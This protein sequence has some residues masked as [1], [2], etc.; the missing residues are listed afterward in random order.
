ME[1]DPDAVATLTFPCYAAG[2]IG[3]RPALEATD[4]VVLPPK[5]LEQVLELR[6]PLPLTLEATPATA[7]AADETPLPP[8]RV[9]HCG[10]V[11]FTAP[12]GIAFVP[13]AIMRKLG[14]GEGDR[15][16]FRTARLPPGTYAQ[17][18]P[19]GEDW[20]RVPERE[21]CLELAL[22]QYQTLTIGDVIAVL[23]PHDRRIH[24]FRCL[25]TR[26]ADAVSLLNTDLTLDVTTPGISRVAG[27]EYG[28]EE[29]VRSLAEA[30]AA[31]AASDAPEPST[32]LPLGTS[33]EHTV[34]P[35][36]AAVFVLQLG[37]L[38]TGTAGGT[39][40][41]HIHVKPLAGDPD[42]YVSAQCRQPSRD[43]HEWAS[44][45][46]LGQKALCIPLPAPERLF[47]AVRPYGSEPARFVLSASVGESSKGQRVADGPPVDA[48]GA[49][50]PNCQRVVP[51]ASLV[52][53]S[54]QCARRN[55]RCASC[56]VVCEVGRAHEKHLFAAHSPM[57]CRCGVQLE[58]QG[59]ALHRQLECRFRLL[60]CLYCPLQV[61]A[62]DRPQHLQD[63]G[64]RSARCLL[65][66]AGFVRWRLK[67]HLEEAHQLPAE[68]LLT[69]YW[70]PA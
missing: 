35:G 24:R 43:D 63:C 37:P 55:V 28:E 58:P 2:A 31:Q 26:P 13:V 19:L 60:P 10:V 49:Q 6:I 62:E 23:A 3:G 5:A 14:V 64:G 22:R 46:T 51:A 9:A 15:V 39:S 65:C 68:G 67:S 50:C 53:H 54:A 1:V 8:W 25:E 36:Q 17:L 57:T 12:D 56:G 41:V 7:D 38:G 42:L 44:D 47:V 59:M 45:D 29:W 27:E 21:A 33:V 4:K 18:Q 20:A 52:L 69:E 70:E 11:D 48:D 66:G 61:S 30:D 32:D 40:G 16:T 34:A